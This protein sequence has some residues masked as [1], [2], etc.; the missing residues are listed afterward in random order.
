MPNTT[1][2]FVK[3]YETEVARSPLPVESS[4]LDL[5]KRG[6]ATS[7]ADP[8]YRHL[9]EHVLPTA[10][11]LTLAVFERHSVDAF[12]FPYQA[13]FAPPISNPIRKVDSRGEVAVRRRPSPATIAGYS[14]VGFPGIVVPMGFGAQGLPAAISFMARPYEEARILGYA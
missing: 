13:A 11:Q 9:I 3:R 6:L 5:L 14:A 12:A 8:T 2:D 10:T 1:A 4:V 7:T